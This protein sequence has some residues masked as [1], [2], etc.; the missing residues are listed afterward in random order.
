MGTTNAPYIA[1][2]QALSWENCQPVI[3][4]KLK[5]KAAYRNIPLPPQLVDCLLDQKN[6]NSDSPYVIQMKNGGALTEASFQSLWGIVNARKTGETKRKRKDGD[7]LK[8]VV[9]EKELGQ[10]CPN[11]AF[12][13]SIDFIVTPHIL[14]H[15]YITNLFLSGM[16]VK[17][18]QYLA[19]HATVEMSL[20]TYTHLVNNK[21]TDLIDGV[22]SVLDKKLEALNLSEELLEEI[23]LRKIDDYS[24][25]LKCLRIA[26]LIN[27]IEAIEWLRYETAGYNPS[28][29]QVSD[30]AFEVAAQHGRVTV[31]DG[32]KI[33]FGELVGELISLIESSKQTIS[34]I[35]N[36]NV[37]VEGQLA[38]LKQENIILM[39]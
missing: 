14:R 7:V 23:E 6:K 8:K 38:L 22:L 17:T 5:S 1:V 2:K 13:F 31:E 30:R 10:S 25:I 16:D 39:L 18:V 32:K 11:H 4:S 9:I 19:G 35:S 26:R 12:T 36:S 15:T 37:S 24:A 29:D 33:M 27:D 20:N 34:N 28:G 3:T 21:P